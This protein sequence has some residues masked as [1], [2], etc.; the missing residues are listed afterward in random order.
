MGTVFVLSAAHG[1]S[2][3]SKCRALQ[4][5]QLSCTNGVEEA[6]RTLRQRK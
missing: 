3:T 6:C 2:A 4:G 5:G 1:Y